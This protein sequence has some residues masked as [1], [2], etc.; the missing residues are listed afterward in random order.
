MKQCNAIFAF[1]L[2]NAQGQEQAWHLDLKHSGDVGKGLAP[3]GKK[4]DG[5]WTYMLL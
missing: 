3:E 5:K 1:N 4:A 2:K